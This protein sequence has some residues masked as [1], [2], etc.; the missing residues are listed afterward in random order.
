MFHLLLVNYGR[1][2]M[3]VKIKWFFEKKLHPSV[4]QREEHS[5]VQSPPCSSRTLSRILLMSLSESN[6]SSIQAS[7][8]YKMLCWNDSIQFF[9]L[10]IKHQTNSWLTS[11]FHY[12]TRKRRRYFHVNGKRWQIVLSFYNECNKCNATLRKLAR[13]CYHWLIL[14][15]QPNINKRG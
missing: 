12:K 2:L 4:Q 15:R 14:S 5:V 1:S 7:R 11:H 9:Y 10:C 8:I 13:T 3:S 6:W